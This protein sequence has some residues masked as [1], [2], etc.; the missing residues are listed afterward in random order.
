MGLN[1]DR[2]GEG[3]TLAVNV[4]NITTTVKKNQALFNKRNINILE[5][6]RYQLKPSNKVP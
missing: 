4:G 3:G 2:Q 1:V 6:L 5:R